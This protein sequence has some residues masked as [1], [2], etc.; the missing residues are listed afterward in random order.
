[1]NHSR[2]LAAITNRKIRIALLGSGDGASGR[3]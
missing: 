3:N 2:H 1:M